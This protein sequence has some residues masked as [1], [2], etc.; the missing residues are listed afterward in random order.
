MGVGAALELESQCSHLH[1]TRV[2]PH[3]THSKGRNSSHR[4]TLSRS[5]HGGTP[6]QVWMGRGQTRLGC[7]GLGQLVQLRQVRLLCLGGGSS[8]VV[9]YLC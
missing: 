9:T 1:Q 6:G 8:L 4:D 5:L 2:I 7:E 3:P